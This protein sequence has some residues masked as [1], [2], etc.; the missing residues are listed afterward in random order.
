MPRTGNGEWASYSQVKIAPNDRGFTVGDVIYD[1]ERTF[2]DER[3][4]PTNG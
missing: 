4:R 2:N 1:T 3:F